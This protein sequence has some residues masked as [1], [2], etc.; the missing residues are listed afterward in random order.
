MPSSA[1]PPRAPKKEHI[2]HRH[3][4]AMPDPYAWLK[5]PE[6]Q[7]VLR[8]PERLQPEIRA[9]LEAENAYLKAAMAE[10]E[11]MQE[12]LY[13][14]M[15]ARI[16]DDDASVPLPDGPWE[17]FVR[18][19]AG[20]QYP[21]HLRRPRGGGAEVVL[22]DI[23]AAAA[24]QAFFNVGAVHHSPDHALLAYAVDTKGSERY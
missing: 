10:T 16:K 13:R 2:E 12:R 21:R 3:G 24:G 9:Y 15:K 14:E 1:A 7:R 17:Y 8:E 11:G 19:E 4:Q 6:W 18:F 22:L 23:P 20:Q 5:D